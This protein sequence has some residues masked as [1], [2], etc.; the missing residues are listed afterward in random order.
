[1]GGNDNDNDSKIDIEIDSSD[2]SSEESLQDDQQQES[3]VWELDESD[4]LLEEQVADLGGDME[5]ETEDEDEGEGDWK[6]LYEKKKA[7]LGKLR[8]HLLRL[9]A[10]FDNFRKRAAKEKEDLVK[11]CNDALLLE[12]LPI[13][14]DLER[15]IEV[16]Q[17]TH[18]FSNLLEGIELVLS[19]FNKVL[20]KNGIIEISS[21]GQ[22]F[23]PNLHD[24]LT[25]VES[26]ETEDNTVVQEYKKGYMLNDKLLRPAQV[27][28]SLNPD[29]EDEK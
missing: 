21:V 15:A 12:V 3:N 19:N 1:M 10:D 2:D 26:A 28:V 9:A 18:E 14:D 7:D 8:D 23:D 27:V 20:E 16:S 13:K 24:A 6:T 11:S 22:K 5:L 17:E 25:R 29:N 4:D